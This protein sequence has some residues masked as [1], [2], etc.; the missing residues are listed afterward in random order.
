[1]FGTKTKPA[2]K[3]TPAVTSSYVLDSNTR[4]FTSVEG[5]YEKGD[6]FTEP[7]GV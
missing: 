7:T 4:T 6:P 2:I 3:I 5:R 1:M